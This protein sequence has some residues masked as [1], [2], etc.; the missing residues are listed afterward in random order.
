M[1][2]YYIDIGPIH[3][4]NTLT[5]AIKAARIAAELDDVEVTV[6]RCVVP[7]DKKSMIDLANGITGK[8]EVVT[9]IRPPRPR[10]FIPNV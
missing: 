6:E 3:F 10:F 1:R 2:F 9:R 4:H 8:G 5:D 7:N